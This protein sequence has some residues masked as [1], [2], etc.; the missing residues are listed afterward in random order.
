MTASS[1]HGG[2]HRPQPRG[3]PLRATPL[4]HAPRAMRHHIELRYRRTCR[5]PA[6]VASARLPVTAR[7]AT[8]RTS[9]PPRTCKK[10]VAIAT[11]F[12]VGE[13]GF[14][15][16]T[17]ASRTL[18]ANRAAPLPAT[19]ERIARRI[20]PAQPRSRRSRRVPGATL[21]QPAP[22]APIP[23]PALPGPRIRRHRTGRGGSPRQRQRRCRPESGSSTIQNGR[24]LLLRM[25]THATTC[26]G[27]APPST[28]VVRS[29][30]RRDARVAQWI[31]RHRP[32]V[33]V[34]GSSPSAGAI[35]LDAS[36]PTAQP[37]EGDTLTW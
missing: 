17:S 13:R 26:R 18:R 8:E 24:C 11:P 27:T 12:R 15:P 23:Y 6:P 37:I 30:R 20:P 25:V 1:R 36:S 7:A 35:R 19:D 21:G 34:G 5:A 3:P 14:E 9:A 16:P 28:P 31:E 22:D 4:H 33:G 2:D 10:G 29:P 32:K